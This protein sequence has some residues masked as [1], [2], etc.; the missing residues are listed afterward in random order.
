MTREIGSWQ[1][2]QAQFDRIRRHARNRPFTNAFTPPKTLENVEFF[3]LNHTVLY[4]EREHGFARIYFFSTALEELAFALKTLPSN[5]ELSISYVDKNKNTDLVNAMISAGFLEIAHYLRMRKIDFEFSQVDHHATFASPSETDQIHNLLYLHFNSIT[6]YLPSSSTLAQFIEEKQ[7][8]VERE[9][10][11]VTGFVIFR[12]NQRTVNFN[13]LLN[14]GR[15]GNGTVLKNSFLKCM[16][17]R[18]VTS[19]FLWVNK[20]NTHAQRLYQRFNWEFDG[21]SDWFFHRSV[22]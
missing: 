21:L 20:T 10:S 7:I 13:Y 14:C 2:I 18:N 19:G 16:A 12:V 9:D 4:L 1:A 22:D 15:P 5:L 11:K 6:D 8:I 17:G 3:Y